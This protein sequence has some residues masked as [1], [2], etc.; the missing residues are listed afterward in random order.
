MKAM[1]RRVQRLA[2]IE[3][4]SGQGFDVACMQKIV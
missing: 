4:E 1:A 2:G 3:R